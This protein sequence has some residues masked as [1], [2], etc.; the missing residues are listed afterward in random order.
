MKALAVYTSVNHLS[1]S[2]RNI[3]AM[4]KTKEAYV[5]FETALWTLRSIVR[6]N[7]EWIDERGR[8][9]YNRN[10]PNFWMYELCNTIIGL[11]YAEGYYFDE[12]FGR[13]Q[14]HEQIPRNTEYFLRV[15]EAESIAR[16]QED[17][18]MIRHLTRLRDY[19]SEYPKD[20]S[21]YN[22]FELSESLLSALNQ[23]AEC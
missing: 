9:N 2:T 19:L 13:I 21:A 14:C 4:L 17:E 3:L 23:F 20:S 16:I 5:R 8:I 11:A 7:I 18:R 12:T 1:I 22:L 15:K 6:K 10:H